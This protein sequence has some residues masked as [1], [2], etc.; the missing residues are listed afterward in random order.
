MKEKIREIMEDCYPDF[1]EI[2]GGVFGMPPYSEVFTEEE[3][4]DEYALL[5]SSGHV[6]GY[7]EGEKCIGIVT[8][9]NKECYNHPVCYNPEKKVAYLSDVAVLPEYRN[10]GIGTALM[11]HVVNCARNE[12]YNIIYMRTLKP[13][14]SMSYGIALKLGFILL[15]ETEVIERE[16][17]DENRNTKDVRIFLEKTL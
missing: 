12:G 13:G 2:Y 3:M 16:R 1:S 8:F 11:K 4:R 15:E 9:N 7:Y 5:T 17:T 10:K 14:E 6:Y